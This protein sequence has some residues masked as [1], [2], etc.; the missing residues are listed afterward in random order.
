ML[1]KNHLI[2]TSIFFFLSGC[3]DPE[4]NTSEELVSPT[5][6]VGIACIKKITIEKAACINTCKNKRVSCMSEAKAKAEKSLPG[7]LIEYEERLNLYSRELEI[8]NVEKKV[9]HE[10]KISYLHDLKEI[11][12]KQNKQLSECEESGRTF[13]GSEFRRKE[14]I[15]EFKE[16][17]KPQE[18]KKPVKPQKPTIQLLSTTNSCN[19]SCNCKSKYESA[20]ILCG[21]KK[22]IHKICIKNCD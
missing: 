17:N 16:K 9:Y 6:A 3:G 19:A 7:K 21:G 11:I 8:Y 14:E 18:P 5:S 12:E 22:V 1:I 4:Y 10:E 15:S 20:F 2:L 13:C